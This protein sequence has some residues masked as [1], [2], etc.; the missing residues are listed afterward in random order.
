MPDQ[1]VIKCLA[2]WMRRAEDV[3][4][5]QKGFHHWLYPH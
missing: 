2:W 4:Q 1:P 3:N 5:L